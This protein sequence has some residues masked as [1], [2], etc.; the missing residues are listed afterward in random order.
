M[1]R[2]SA[3]KWHIG[4][5]AWLVAAVLPACHSTRLAVDDDGEVRRLLAEDRYHEALRQLPAALAEWHELELEAGHSFEGAA[6]YLYSTA[7][8]Q[9]AVRGDRDWGVILDDPAIP[10]H[11][12]S[13]L[14]FEILE[15]RLGKGSVYSASRDLFVIPRSGPVN[16]A[17]D[18]NTLPESQAAPPN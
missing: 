14:V 13:D 12:K 7:L 17:T 18:M 3:V 5:L 16:L 9:T 8:L 6:G 1:Y 10:Y 15:N 11:Y 4:W 2:D